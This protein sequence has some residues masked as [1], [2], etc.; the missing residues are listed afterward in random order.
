MFLL[1]EFCF[2]Q[3]FLIRVCLVVFLFGFILLGTFFTYWIWLLAIIN[4]G[5]VLIEISLMGIS[6]LSYE[7]FFL[8]FPITYYSLLTAMLLISV[9]SILFFCSI[10]LIA[11]VF[12]LR[13]L[14]LSSASAPMLLRPPPLFFTYCSFQFY[15]FGLRFYFLF[16]MFSLFIV[17]LE[18][19]FLLV[20]EHL[21]KVN[22]D[23][24][25]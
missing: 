11:C 13:S 2:W 14:I 9:Q 3:S 5:K 18:S 10:L 25:L 16:H 8:D 15:H 19:S 7:P 20:I 17:V 21:L 4:P 23:Y 6:L 22:P 12:F 1:S 24:H